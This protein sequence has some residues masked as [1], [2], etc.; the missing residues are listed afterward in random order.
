MTKRIVARLMVLALVLTLSA[1]AAGVEA[2]AFDGG[3][4]SDRFT[5]V[6]RTA[7]YHDAVQWAVDRGM[8]N[9]V[10]SDSFDPDATATRAM[11]VTML[12]RMAGE[13]T[14]QSPV[15]F[16]DAK[17]GAW[18]VD[19]V[20]WAA[21]S[22]AVNGTS[23][24]TFSP[25]K[26]V[27]REQ[28]AAILYRYAR[29]QGRGFTDAWAFPLEYSDADQV[30]EYAYEP[31]C[32]MT[33][34]GVITGM[35][36]GTLAPKASATRAQ[37][38]VMFRRFAAEPMN[39]AEFKALNPEEQKQAFAA[40]TGPEIYELVK[41]S[42]ESWPVTAYDLITADNAKETI[43]LY[44]SNGD[45]HFNLAWPPYGGFLP[46]SIASLGDLSGKLDVSRDGG[47][48][49]YS[50][51][52]GKNEDGSYPNDAQRSVPKSS[53]TVRTGILDADQYKRVVDVVTNGKST[54]S[55]IAELQ[56]MG[57]DE[58]IAARFLSDQTAWLSR[59]EVAGKD[60]I[61]DGVKA[62]GHS[63]EAK[64]GYYGVT[65]PWL[66][67]DLALEGG[68][69]QLEPVFSWGTLCASGLISDTGTAE[70]H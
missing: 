62:A 36:D 38:A 61:S 5:D 18:Y 63:V 26:P 6:S 54:E 28:L 8:M 24:D 60:S 42:D 1:R 31:M 34:H 20:A 64:Y 29:S 11:V 66:A 48:G 43:V 23:T 35:D 25:N 9:G 22:G 68:G 65:A 37:A 10:S 4:V 44:D 51:S 17:D 32:W 69:G 46:E 47:D 16:T 57:Y 30:A 27:T 59:D 19:A 55:R 49:G 7:T 70:I 52:Y 40:M 12:W 13:P 15:P 45:L 58:E 50:M 21:E 41:N 67:G 3:D 14:A 56:A 33:I 53:A 2:T 39:Y